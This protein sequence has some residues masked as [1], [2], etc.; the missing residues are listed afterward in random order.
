MSILSSYNDWRSEIANR[1]D[2]KRRM[3]GLIIDVCV[4]CP[5]A[6]RQ[7]NRPDDVTLAR[8]SG[9]LTRL[10][11]D[12]S[13]AE[14]TVL[15]TAKGCHRIPGQADVAHGTSFGQM[16][17]LAVKVPFGARGGDFCWGGWINSAYEW[18]KQIID[19]NPNSFPAGTGAAMVQQVDDSIAA[20]RLARGF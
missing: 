20:F 18:S 19:Q 8:F 11:N 12:L 2:I 9:A 10:W 6:A 14:R 13:L 4:N 16:I 5:G 15:M 3:V 7:G 17:Q 1:R